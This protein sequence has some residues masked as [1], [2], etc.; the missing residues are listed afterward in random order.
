M[1]LN[2][3]L[4][5]GFC[6]GM[7]CLCSCQEVKGAKDGKEE[8][9]LFFLHNRF[10][11]EH[12]IDDLHPDFGRVE[13][14]EIVDK[15]SSAGFTVISEQRRG[16]VNAR[17]YALNVKSQVDSLL[18]L[19]VNPTSITVVG[20]SKGGYI[21]QYVSTLARNPDLNFVFIASVAPE[22][23]ENIPDISFC[24]N[25]LNIHEQSDPAGVSAIGRFNQSDQPI[26]HFQEIGLTTGLGHGIVFKALDE[27]ITPTIQWA[28]GDYYAMA[29]NGIVHKSKQ[30]EVSRLSEHLYV[31]VSYLKQYNNTPCNGMIYVANGEAIV[32]DT[33]TDSLASAELIGWLE[34]E[35]EVKVEA[36]VINHYHIDCLGG[37]AVFH[38]AEVTSYA[39]NAT[40][41]LASSDRA[42]SEVVPEVG[43]ADS[44]L[45]MVGGST[46]ENRSFGP[47][48]SPDNIVSYVHAENALFGGCLIKADQAGKGSLTDA[49][50]SEWPKTV[51]KVKEH[52]AGKIAYLVPGHGGPGSVE[53]LD[54]TIDLFSEVGKD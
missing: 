26:N 37:L 52:Y 43:F 23:P 15:F 16:N 21:A 47:G 8:K 9:Y 48:H 29:T 35:L 30:L 40:I 25:I 36:V 6:L 41:E 27:W 24:G 42:H 44:L 32:F 46:I 2:W 5:A 22:D 13:Y 50:V 10:L 34:G 12:S 14:S 53:L 1:N 20:T 31:H 18:D 4:A 19:G 49:N 17:A 11:E 39:S 33:P 7:L 3:L 38:N 45:L 28:G 54:Y 51:A